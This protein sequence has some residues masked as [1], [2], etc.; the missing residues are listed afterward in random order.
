[1]EEI[2]REHIMEVQS[3]SPTLQDAAESIGSQHH[4]PVAERG[5][6]QIRHICMSDAGSPRPMSAPK[7]SKALLQFE[8]FGLGSARSGSA[9]WWTFRVSPV[10]H[11]T[12]LYLH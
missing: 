12:C 7:G 1:M 3:E 2:E 5:A 9:I 11:G 8:M 4:Y 6:L 10:W